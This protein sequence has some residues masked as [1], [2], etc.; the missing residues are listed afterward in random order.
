MLAEHAV[1]KFIE[2]QM[3]FKLYARVHRTVNN[4]WGIL[5]IILRISF[6]FASQL[7]LMAHLLFFFLINYIVSFSLAYI[8]KMSLIFAYSWHPQLFCWWRGLRVYNLGSPSS[9]S[10]AAE[11]KPLGACTLSRQWQAIVIL[12]SLQC[13]VKVGVK[14]LVQLA[15]LF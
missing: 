12:T 8:W 9:G 7:L 6:W 2:L 4:F 13:R 11:A 3:N 15:N 1:Q 10:P 5:K 14:A